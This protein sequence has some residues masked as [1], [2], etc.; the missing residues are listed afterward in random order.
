MKTIWSTIIILFFSVLPFA[1]F[2]ILKSL[3]V[4][5]D[6]VN[7]IWIE[8]WQILTNI[9]ISNFSID[10]SDLFHTFFPAQGV[11]YILF[12]AIGSILFILYYRTNKEHYWMKII[13]IIGLFPVVAPLPFIIIFLLLGLLSV[14]L[15]II[16]LI[17]RMT[18]PIIYVVVVI[19]IS[20]GLSDKF[21]KKKPKKQDLKLY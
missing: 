5:D 18:L 7:W 16:K 4:W 11:L 20:L 1:A 13:G 19:L 2:V 21:D 15:E 6:V 17:L 3:N 12:F 8:P 10:W 9:S 14:L